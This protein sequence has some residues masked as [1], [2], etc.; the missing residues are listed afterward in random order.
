MDYGTYMEQKRIWW[1]VR[2]AI[3]IFVDFLKLANVT[4]QINRR[5]AG[6]AY[7]YVCFAIRRTNT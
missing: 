5:A 4:I 7:D 3:I 2:V 6:D 1:R